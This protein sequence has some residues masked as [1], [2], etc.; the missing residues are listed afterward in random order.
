MAYSQSAFNVMNNN[1]RNINRKL[2]EA[3]HL[4][5]K[6]AFTHSVGIQRAVSPQTVRTANLELTQNGERKTNEERS[7]MIL[8]ADVQGK[9]L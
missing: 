1:W 9:P 6:G 3:S 5:V 8:K 4:P 7:A 2:A